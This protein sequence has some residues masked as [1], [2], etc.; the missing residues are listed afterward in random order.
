MQKARF[1]KESRVQILAAY[2]L[3]GIKLSRVFTGTTDK[4]L[5]EDF[6]EQL[7]HHCRKWPQPES[8]LIMDNA[9]FHF[10]DKIEAMCERAGVGI[11]RGQI[12]SKKSLGRSRHLRLPDERKR[13]A[14]E[15]EV[16]SSTLKG[17]SRR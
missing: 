8:V 2:T 12:R 7:L 14:S 6:V 3:R 16:L 13:K 17:A 1:Q 15:R 11:L 4:A 9:S 5:F 10:S